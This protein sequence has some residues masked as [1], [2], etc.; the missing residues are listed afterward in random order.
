MSA[1]SVQTL[2]I[3]RW[4]SFGFAAE[5]EFSRAVDAAAR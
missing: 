2:I 3:M 5:C 4:N 1:L